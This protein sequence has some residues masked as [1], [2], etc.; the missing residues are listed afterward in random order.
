[1]AV[2]KWTPVALDK[3]EDLTLGEGIVYY[4]LDESE[5]AEMGATLGGCELRLNRKLREVPWDGAYGAVRGM[6]E[7]ETFKPQL[8]IN[9]LR[10]DYTNLAYANTITVSDGSDA[11]GTYKKIALRLNIE[12]TDIVTNIGFKGYKMNGD[13]VKI[14]IL[15]AFNMDSFGFGHKNKQEVVSPMI[16]TGFYAND[17]LITPPFEV[18]DYSVS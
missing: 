11:D 13:I 2:M 16:Y 4:N 7:V 10:I 12:S 1:M 14:K 18:W 3:A 15:R 8:L 6:K 17:D 5:E 9:F